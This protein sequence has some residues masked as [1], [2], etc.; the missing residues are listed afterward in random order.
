MDTKAIVDGIRYRWTPASTEVIKP[1]MQRTEELAEDVLP[2]L[3]KIRK[4]TRKPDE[5][6]RD[7]SGRW[8]WR[9]DLFW[10][11]LWRLL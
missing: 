1:F 4:P 11:W 10:V 2:T 7:A 9:P 5:S 8:L 3:D 6:G